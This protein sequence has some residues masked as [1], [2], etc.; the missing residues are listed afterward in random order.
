MVAKDLADV[1][2]ELHIQYETDW[3]T[4][5]AALRSKGLQMYRYFWSADI[6]DPDNFL[7]VLCG[8]EYQYNFMHYNNP[9]VDLLLAQALVETDIIKR[10]NLYRQAE[11]MI[12]EDA[13]LIPFMYWVFEAVFQ[14]YVKG[15]EISA[16]GQPYI[17]LKKIWLDRQ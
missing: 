13:P 9:K 7:N 8:S 6:P 1:G 10:V 14:P 11:S 4:F 5:E 2:V 16:L 17:P 3:P 12:L 15:L